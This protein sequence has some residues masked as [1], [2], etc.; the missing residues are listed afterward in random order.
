LIGVQ[1]LEICPPKAAIWRGL[2][3]KQ[4]TIGTTYCGLGIRRRSCWCGDRVR[5]RIQGRT[6]RAGWNHQGAPH[7]AEDQEPWRERPRRFSEIVV[8]RCL[9]RRVQWLWYKSAAAS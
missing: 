5:P 7:R 6:L 1:R 8:H 2:W 9:I 4:G 3:R